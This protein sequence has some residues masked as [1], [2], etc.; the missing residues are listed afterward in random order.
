ML[1]IAEC[2]LAT[3]AIID[4][5]SPHHTVSSKNY[6]F[7]PAL[8]QALGIVGLISFCFGVSLLLA[9]YHHSYSFDVNLPFIHAVTFAGVLLFA[10]G[11]WW[12][13]EYVEFRRHKTSLLHDLLHGYWNPLV[14]ILVA[15]AVVGVSMELI[16]L[17]HE[18]W[19]Y[20]NWP[21]QDFHVLGLPVI[22]IAVAWPIHFVMFLSLFRAIT[23]KDSAEVWHAPAK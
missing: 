22:M 6:R 18:Y 5:F 21:L 13:S 12:C 19:I 20:A 9:D 10:C 15:T 1:M 17:R 16:N 2:Y 11:V 14:A 23:A 8:Y 7:E 3:K 4:K